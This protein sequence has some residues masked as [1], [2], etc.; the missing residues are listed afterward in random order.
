MSELR[1][2]DIDT[3]K[4]M[5]YTLGNVI[6]IWNFANNP[7]VYDFGKNFIISYNNKN[8]N[9]LIERIGYYNDLILSRLLNPS[10]LYTGALF[11]SCIFLDKYNKKPF[12]KFYR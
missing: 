6:I 5:I 10:T 3:I 9:N 11:I 2:N 12:Y 8:S 4:E 1:K 7:L